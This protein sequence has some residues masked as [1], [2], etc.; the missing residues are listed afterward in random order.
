MTAPQGAPGPIAYAAAT[1]R[2]REEEGLA[3]IYVTG[4]VVNPDGSLARL[5]GSQSYLFDV[6]VPVTYG[7]S[8]SELATD[9]ENALASAWGVTGL[10]DVKFTPSF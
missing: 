1:M 8:T 4:C 7:M 9:V 5:G 2:I 3:R 6:A 10:A